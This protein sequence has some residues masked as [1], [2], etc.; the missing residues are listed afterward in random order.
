MGNRYTKSDEELLQILLQLQEKT[1]PIKLSIGF[2]PNGTVNQGIILHNAPSA[3]IEKIV[4]KGYICNLTER[5]LHVYKV[6]E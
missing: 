6:K 1:A 5:G 4:E 3:V 2:V